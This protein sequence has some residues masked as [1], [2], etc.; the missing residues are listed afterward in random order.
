MAGSEYYDHTSYPTTGAAGSSSALRAELDL[1]EAGFG[2]LPDLSGNGGKLVRVNAG[3]TAL[4]AYDSGTITTNTTL[5]VPAAYATLAA[6]FTYLRTKTIAPG[7]TV[8]ISIAAGTHDYSGAS[9]SMNHPQGDQIRVVGAGSGSTVL[10]WLGTATGID[11]LTVT[12][13]NVLGYIDALHI[14]RTAH[15]GSSISTGLLAN[16]AAAIICGS[17]IKVSNHYYGTAARYGSYI[18]YDSN[19][20]DGAG[21]VGIWA[22]VGSTVDCS[23]AIVTNTA[24]PLQSLGFGIQAEY[25]S[26][27]NCDSASSSGNKIAGIA[28]LSGST[29]RAPSATANTNTGSGLFARD[30]GVIE[31][32]GATANNNTR[33]G[34]EEY[35]SGRVVDGT[36]NVTTITRT[37]NTLGARLAVAVLNA[38]STLGARVHA[39]SGALRI[40]TSDTSSV[41]FNTSNG[42]ALEVADN[43]AAS[44][45][46]LR[47]GPATAALSDQVTLDF[48]HG[49]TAN[50]GARYRAKGT[51]AH[52]FSTDSGSAIQFEIFHTAGANRRVQVSGSNGGNPRINVSGGS[53]DVASAVV[54]TN[55]TVGTTVG[56]AGAASALPANPLGYLTTSI[57]GTTC[58]IPYYN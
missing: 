15:A 4:E 49:T 20:V 8:T 19:E 7:V 13:G 1:I 6:A 38:D 54:F 37:G 10:T 44:T 45:G 53:L 28:S 3:A 14:T 43:G 58:K 11:A 33:Y 46:V 26:T 48:T 21:D 30:G 22:Y 23:S 52:F 47:I 17:D 42:G 32:I 51:G 39:S 16:N 34:I 36:A 35:T 27:I 18:K 57:N 12:D 55:Q 56:A 50:V 31:A 41:Y 5:N 24:D 9:V 40:D 29:V 2:K 25:G